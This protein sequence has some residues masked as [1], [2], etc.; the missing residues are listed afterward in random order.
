MSK[1]LIITNPSYDR[2]T[3]YL[4]AW[5]EVAIDLARSAPG[6]IVLELNGKNANKISLEKAVEEYKP[7][8]II[9]NGHGNHDFITGFD[10]EILVRATE[11]E[12]MLKGAIVHAMSCDAGKTLGPACIKIG[13]IAYIGYKEE[14]KLTHLDKTTKLDQL[15]DQVARLFLEPAFEFIVALLQGDSVEKAFQRSRKMCG[16]TLLD[17]VASPEASKYSKVA[18]GLYHNYKHQV[19]LGDVKATF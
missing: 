15:N 2:V 4:N 3:E 5:S 13:G 16:D 8:L 10:Q 18:G 12:Q 17:F 9:F 6:V 1:V 19:C 7:Q 11:N 14:F